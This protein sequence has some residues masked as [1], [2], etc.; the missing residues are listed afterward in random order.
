MKE[1]FYFFIAFSMMLTGIF[2][3]VP[4]AVNVLGFSG[5]TFFEGEIWRILSYPFAHV[6]L[7]HLLENLVALFVVILLSYE[8]NLG[9]KE[10]LAVFLISGILV[11]FFS[12]IFFPYLLIVG[13]SLGIYSLFGALALKEQEIMPKYFFLGIFWMIIFLNLA[14]TVY[15]SNNFT[16]AAYHGAGFVSG[17]GIISIKRFKP[18]KRILQ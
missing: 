13:S 4:Q 16:Q 6:T 9:L 7:S 5:E 8:L 2:V 17:L 1:L 11:A 18:K 10:F 12:G 3:V 15:V 14:Y